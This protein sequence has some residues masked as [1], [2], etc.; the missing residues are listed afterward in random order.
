MGQQM[1]HAD[2]RDAQRRVSAL[3][4]EFASIRARLD[5]W[6]DGDGPDGDVGVIS[7]TELRLESP[8]QKVVSA[9]D[10]SE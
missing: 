7:G 8:A 10:S 1:F 3:R 9:G 6:P 4:V 2:L 5:G